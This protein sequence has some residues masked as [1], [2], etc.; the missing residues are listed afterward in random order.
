MAAVLAGGADAVLSHAS[1][2]AAWELRPIGSGA[3][4]RDDPRRTPG[5]R[6]TNG[7]RVASEQDARARRT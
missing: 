6:A 2:A 5:A 1:A 3:D 4:P 7:I